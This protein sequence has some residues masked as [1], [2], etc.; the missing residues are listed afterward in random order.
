MTDAMNSQTTE[1]LKYI[2]TQSEFDE[3]Q[4]IGQP[5]PLVVPENPTSKTRSGKTETRLQNVMSSF[6]SRAN[7]MKTR[8]VKQTQTLQFLPAPKVNL[9]PGGNNTMST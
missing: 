5:C 4:N 1:D 7:K 6:S 9:T 8:D 2:L 3:I